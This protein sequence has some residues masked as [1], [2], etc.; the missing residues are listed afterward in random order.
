MT[1][2]RISLV[3]AVMCYVFG[4]AQASELAPDTPRKM[5]FVFQNNCNHSA[6]IEKPILYQ[7]GATAASTAKH[8][9][10]HKIVIPANEERR[11][12]TTIGPCDMIRMIGTLTDGGPRSYFH[13]ESHCAPDASVVVVQIYRKSDDCLPH[14]KFCCLSN[15]TIALLNS[16][17][18]PEEDDDTAYDD[19]A[20]DETAEEEAPTLAVAEPVKKGWFW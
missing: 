9:L 16:S 10:G 7:H 1:S 15:K 17:T 3:L 14:M 18:E 20:Y 5:T 2:P 13:S 6:L 12:T 11:F 4:S 8:T 19:T